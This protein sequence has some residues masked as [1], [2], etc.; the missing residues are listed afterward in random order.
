M[1]SRDKYNI[2]PFAGENYSV[3]SFRILS[4]LKENGVE[5]AVEDNTFAA[6]TENKILEA[7]AQALIIAAVADSHLE[8]L[9]DKVSAYSMFEN[10]EKNFKKKGVRSKLFLRRQLNEIKFNDNNDSLMEHF[11]VLEKIFSQLKDADGELTEEEKVN[12]ILLSMPPSY[13]G[14][15]TALETMENLKLDFVKNRLLGEEEKRKKNDNI[16]KSKNCAFVCYSC[17]KPGHKKF[18]CRERKQNQ[19]Q[20][21]QNQSFRKF[22][23]GSGNS[24]GRGRG[25]DFSR[26]RGKSFVAGAENNDEETNRVVFMCDRETTSDQ[27]Q[28]ECNDILWC[29][30]SGCTDHLVNDKKLFSKYVQLNK[31]RTIAAAK[32]GVK[33]EAIGIGTIEASCICNNIRIPITI[34]NV[35]Y[36]PE[37]R[38]NLLSV[39]KMESS[40]LKVVFSNGNVKVYFNNRLRMFGRKIDSLY[41]IKMNVNFVDLDCNFSSSTERCENLAK[42]WHRRYG[43]LGF[44]NLK[45]LRRNNLVSGLEKLKPSDMDN[46]FCEPCILGKIVRKPFNKKGFRAQKPLQLVHTDVCGPI[47]PTS[48]DGYNY[49]VT[50]IDDYTHFVVVYLLKNKSE[51]FEKFKAYYNYATNHFERKIL[52]LRADNGGEYISKDLQQFCRD[53]GVVLQYTIPYNPEM[54]GV[55]ERMNRTLTDKVRTLLI[56]SQLPKSLWGEAIYFSAYVTNRSPTASLDVTPSEMWEGRKPNVENLR[57]FGSIG[58]AHIPKQIRTKLEP[59]GVKLRMVGYAPGGYRLWN[60]NQSKICIERNVKFQEEELKDYVELDGGI[61]HENEEVIEEESSTVLEERTL[62]VTKVEEKVEEKTKPNED[63]I[64]KRRIVKP[65][66]FNDY[67]VDFD[68]EED[69][70][71]EA[72]Y[73]ANCDVPCTYKDIKYNENRDSWYAAV[74]EELKTLEENDTWEITEMPENEKLIDCKWIFTKKKLNNSELYK[75]R[76]VARGFQQEGVFSDIYSPVLKLQTLR[77]LLSIAVQ[78]NYEIH[79]MDVKGAFLYGNINETVYL[80]PPEGVNIDKNCVLKLRKSLYG[81]KK[82]A[83]YWYEK[84]SK[85]MLSH[86]FKRSENDFCLYIKNNLYI[87]LYVDDLLILSNSILEISWIKQLLNSEF[88]MKDLGSKNLK[89][90]GINI[91]KEDDSLFLDQKDYL[92]SVLI[93][94]GMLDCNSVDT[95][96]DVNINL[97][98]NCIVDNSLEQRCRSCIGSLMYA[99]VGTRP[100]L[101]AAVSYLSRFQSN[102]SAKLWLCLKRILRYIKGTLDYKLEYVRN[103]EASPLVGYADA[104]YAR[105]SDRKSTTGFLFKV[106]SNTVVW[107]SKKQNTVALSTTEAE[108]VSLCEA[109]TEASWIKK[110]L[111]DLN[112]N[113]KTTIIY[114]DNQSTI[115]AVNN[116]DQKRLKHME[117]KYNFV[118][119]KVEDKEIKV[120]YI[121]TGE[122]IADMF[123]KPLNKKTFKYLF[124]KV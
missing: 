51:V 79:Q 62:E 64:E 70:V 112:V 26:G 65:K 35:F 98:E 88:Q 22:Q 103:R 49:F 101:C 61:I 31:P 9:R 84:F 117:V 75:A 59:K 48:W 80:K 18:E 43:H 15:I 104:D 86:G 74:K 21:N 38:K 97:G 8:Y 94:F 57:V 36:V 66:R 24:R 11:V 116:P 73:S 17:G 37:V 39:D 41:I 107:K 4:I 47:T 111:L 27:C 106:F 12:Y 68:G 3:W 115:K 91:K 72:L 102:P 23:N 60:E 13:E 99:A 108:F 123:T 50:F 76:L 58:Y 110:L 78:R 1:M 82:S 56:D 85:L 25:R 100:D 83:K 71:F 122:Q 5:K 113:F 6:K 121:S 34:T 77:I 87:L 7:K 119:H 53:K 30:D 124:K 95:P 114:E 118:K 109:A 69:S 63:K 90:L 45:L 16:N 19:H 2:V 10:L 32:N 44:D 14:I 96:M 55:A 28:S 92:E 89:Y 46:N 93:K 67:V 52:K 29:V 40:G 33:L 42:L 54:N 81:L 120:E 105:D 20:S